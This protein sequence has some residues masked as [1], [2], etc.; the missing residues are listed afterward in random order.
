MSVRLQVVTKTVKKEGDTTMNGS[1]VTTIEPIE[2][3]QEFIRDMKAEPNA[4]KM[5]NFV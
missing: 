5:V 2:K 4:Q 1:E 3:T